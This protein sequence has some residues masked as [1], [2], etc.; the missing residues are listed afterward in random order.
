MEGDKDIE[1]F[2]HNPQSKRNNTKIK[3]HKLQLHL[4]RTQVV[5]FLELNNGNHN[6]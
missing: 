4:K 5:K 2:N 6:G 3:L 1:L